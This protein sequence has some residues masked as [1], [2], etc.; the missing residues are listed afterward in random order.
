MLSPAFLAR[1]CMVTHVLAKITKVKNNFING[2]KKLKRILS[3]LFGG[4]RT[5]QVK[6]LPSRTSSLLL[7]LLRTRSGHRLSLQHFATVS[8]PNMAELVPSGFFCP[9]PRFLQRSE[10]S[11]LGK[12]P[13]FYVDRQHTTPTECSSILSVDVNFFI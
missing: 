10:H 8:T 5:V 7:V 3:R 9:Q 11:L 4:R 6:N 13:A 12:T 1:N 2:K